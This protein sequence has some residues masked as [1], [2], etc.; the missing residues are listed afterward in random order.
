MT[1]AVAEV[2]GPLL[3]RLTHLERWKWEAT[4]VLA[5]WDAVYDSLVPEP[6]DLGRS[7]AD[8]VAERLAAAEIELGTLRSIDLGETAAALVDLRKAEAR[9]AELEGADDSLAGELND[10]DML[11]G[12]L[13]ERIAELE[14]VEWQEAWRRTVAG[15]TYY[16]P[17][18]PVISGD[19]VHGRVA[20]VPDEGETDA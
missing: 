2:V 13:I 19:D 1:A 16:S 7:K 3:D 8:V 4:E 9:I 11:N 6:G 10:A 17:N 12:E 18:P 15:E 5:R 20:F 14:A